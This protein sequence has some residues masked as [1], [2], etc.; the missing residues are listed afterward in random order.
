MRRFESDTYKLYDYE[1]KKLAKKH[2]V[3]EMSPDLLHDFALQLSGTGKRRLPSDMKSELESHAPQV[4]A[5]SD[6]TLTYQGYDYPS[7]RNFRQDWAE[8]Q[9]TNVHE[10]IMEMVSDLPTS[11]IPGKTPFQK[12]AN[13]AKKLSQKAPSTKDSSIEGDI[14]DFTG[15]DLKALKDEIIKEID[16]LDKLDDLDRQLLSGDDNAAFL[17]MNQFY[18]L[19]FEIEQAIRSQ[20]RI[21]PTPRTTLFK[22]QSGDVIIPRASQGIYDLPYAPSRSLLSRRR[23]AQKLIQGD[24][25][26]PVKY[27]KEKS[28]PLLA[29]I[30][31]CSGSMSGVKAL[32]GLGIL[33]YLVKEVEKGN[34]LGLFS[35]FE[36]KC[37][38]FYI[39]D[40]EKM[41]VVEWFKK[42]AKS[43]FDMS[44]TD[45]KACI[46]EALEEIDKVEMLYEIDSSQKELIVVNDGA[47][48]AT[49]LKVIHLKGSKLHAFILH[50][51]N[52]YLGK[53]AV[54]SG[55]M[56]KTNL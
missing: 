33:W 45:V 18:R 11:L 47:D 19:I 7:Q 52:D 25:S 24:V 42:I 15:L 50:R 34:C 3:E 9:Y 26:V 27:E 17:E 10:P 54:S 28:T 40:S 35:F 46:L 6:G 48:D 22:S 36:K 55:G 39:L 43:K 49:G 37:Q 2:G 30:L 5:N 38:K 1:I 23:L 21:S 32:K 51:T 13:V 53:V 8:K 56:Y 31:D 4:L 44:V 14:P 41:D 16:C 20:A 12:A 29:M